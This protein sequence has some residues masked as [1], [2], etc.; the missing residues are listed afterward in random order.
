MNNVLARPNCNQDARATS[1]F[2]L[3]SSLNDVWRAAGENKTWNYYEPFHFRPT[4]FI[5]VHYEMHVLR[6]QII[7]AR[8][9][10]T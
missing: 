3:K 7:D 5:R 8:A 10:A 6:R 9:S 2:V 4:W 1:H